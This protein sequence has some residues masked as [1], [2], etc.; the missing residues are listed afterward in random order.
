VL[1][2]I[3]SGLMAQEEL[4][5]LGFDGSEEKLTKPITHLPK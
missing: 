5:T 2:C 3:N 4:T 1:F